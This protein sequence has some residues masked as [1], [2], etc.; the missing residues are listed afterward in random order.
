MN[1]FSK[2][3][4]IIGVGGME[5]TKELRYGIVKDCCQFME[6]KL[7]IDFWFC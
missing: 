7:L 1:W 5:I 2:D 4:Y 6:I 3:I